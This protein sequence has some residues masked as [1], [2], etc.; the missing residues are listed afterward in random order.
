MLGTNLVSG[1]AAFDVHRPQEDTGEYKCSKCK[2][3][4]GW[5]VEEDGHRYWVH[6]ECRERKILEAK[7]RKAHIP[8]EYWNIRLP[9]SDTV[10]TFAHRDVINEEVY[11]IDINKFLKQYIRTLPHQISTRKNLLLFGNN[12]SGKSMVSMII[13][14]EA[15]KMGYSCLYTTM[16]HFLNQRFNYRDPDAAKFVDDAREVDV[17]VIDDMG[18]EF[19]SADERIYSEIEDLLRHRFGKEAITI[20]TTNFNPIPTQ[21]DPS[22]E[23]ASV[24]KS[25]ISSIQS[26]LV[27][28][29]L[30]LEVIIER[31]YRHTLG[32]RL[33]DDFDLSSME[34]D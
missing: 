23:P 1:D 28:N 2:D 4:L 5:T 11:Q 9:I 18:K 20:I 12:G 29:C 17:L 19:Y 16:K 6:C 34:V 31:D 26:L 10:E 33:W 8:Y 13:S 14:T 32:P 15:I 3:R 24:V 21:S 22:G 25:F 30:F 7:F 27:A